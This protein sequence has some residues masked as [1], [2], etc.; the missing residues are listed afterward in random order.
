MQSTVNNVFSSGGK[1]GGWKEEAAEKM[2]R[3]HGKGEK[4]RD[5]GE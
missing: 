5:G 3:R 1:K 2:A 4:Y